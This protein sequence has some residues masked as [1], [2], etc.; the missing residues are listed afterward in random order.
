MRFIKKII[1]SRYTLRLYRFDFY[2]VNFLNALL[3]SW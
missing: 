2:L 3:M 1:A